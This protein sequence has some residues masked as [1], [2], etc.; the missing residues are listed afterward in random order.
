MDDDNSRLNQL[1]AASRAL[2]GAPHSQAVA[3]TTA[4]AALVLTR[5]TAAFVV[6]RTAAGKAMSLYES[7]GENAAALYAEREEHFAELIEAAL[8][9][10]RLV[11]DE[12][13]GAALAVPL[14]Q[15][16]GSETVLVVCSSDSG[17]RFR[18]GEVDAIATLAALTSAALQTVDLQDLQRNFFTH[19]TDILVMVM[20][21]FVDG[22]A[23]HAEKVARN[24]NQLGREMGLDDDQ[25]RR[26]HFAALLHD[27][28]MLRVP[29]AGHSDPKQ[30]MKH[31][32]LGHRMMSRI[33]LWEGAA[34]S[35]L[36]H[37]EWYDGS[38]YPDG[39]AREA[40]PLEARIIS[41]ADAF[42]AMLRP[43]GEGGGMSLEGALSEIRNG[44]GTQF[45][46]DVVSAFARLVDAGQLAV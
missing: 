21:A 1:L 18:A 34:P 35:I 37:H 9:D 4:K 23:G 32:R 20:D 6:R 7:S 27:I 25:L 40:I 16:K 8:R 5:G 15:E 12:R 2:S 45:D 43:T 26:L 46:P 3:E 29:R 44:A 17:A 39:L 33:R 28:G 14:V 22:R 36:H 24:V 13:A 38:G 19:V 41:V 11:T 31:P 42:D 10:S 30:F